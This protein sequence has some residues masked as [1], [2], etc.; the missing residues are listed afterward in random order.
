MRILNKSIKKI[1]L[2]IA[3]VGIIGGGYLLYEKHNDSKA[4]P[5]NSFMQI[6]DF[7]LDLDPNI[8]PEKQYT[9]SITTFDHPDRLMKDSYIEIYSPDGQ[10]V[11]SQYFNGNPK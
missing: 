9:I 6:N 8:P 10:L 7:Y 1:I 5:P 2:I 3:I 4:T 11:K